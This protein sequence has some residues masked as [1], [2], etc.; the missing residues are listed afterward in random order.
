MVPPSSERID[1]FQVIRRLGRGGM[2]SVYLARDPDTDRLVA[3]KLLREGFDEE[4]L[5]VRFAAEARSASALRHINIVT[6]FQTGTFLDRPFIVMEYI[7]GE[8]FADL[9]ARAPSVPVSRKLQLMDELCTGLQYAHAK[10]VVHRDIKPA[11]VMIDQDG[12]VRILD[13]GI[14]RLGAGGL[15][16][17][18]AVIGTLNYM[19]PEQL[20]GQS[21][22]ARVDIFAAGLVLYEL[23]S[24][25]RAFPQSFPEVLRHIAVEEPQ[26]LAA[27][28]P[29]IHP[30]LVALVDRCLRK[31]PGDRY[32]DFGTL[33]RD[34]SAVRQA[35]DTQPVVLPETI[36]RT[37]PDAVS[38]DAGS[39]AADSPPSDTLRPPSASIVQDTIRSDSGRLQSDRWKT[40]DQITNAIAPPAIDETI[41][42]PPTGSTPVSPVPPA[43]TPAPSSES[44]SGASAAS[45]PAPSPARTPSRAPAPAAIVVPA[46][47]RAPAPR[48]ARAFVSAVVPIL[49]PVLVAAAIGGGVAIWRATISQPSSSAATPAPAVS[50][51]PSSAQA[52]AGGAAAV[53]S[54]QDREG[55]RLRTL[56]RAEWS[57]GESSS[58]L[59][60]MTEAQRLDPGSAE[61][62]LLKELVGDA[63]SRA[64]A[65]ERDAEAKK[66]VNTSAYRSGSEKLH[67]ADQLVRSG[68]MLQALKGY[69]EAA[70]QFGRAGRTAPVEPV[71]VGG[72]IKPPRQT[73]TVNPDYPAMARSARLEGVVILEATIG[74]TGK[75]TDVRVLRSIPLLDIAAMDAV[76]QWE[77]EPTILNGKAVPVI[78]TVTARFTLTPPQ[79]AVEPVRVGGAIKPPT[80]VKRVNP[81]YPADAQAAG[82]SGTV[83][84]DVTIGVDGTVTDVRVLRSIPKLDQ[85]AVDAVRQW[86]YAPTLRD[87]VAIPVITTVAVQFTLQPAAAPAPPPAAPARG[88]PIP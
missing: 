84:L 66:A 40:A 37:P 43:P 86:V 5:R 63:H 1:K 22:D 54:D 53:L 51:T 18:G 56:A 36:I 32:P 72:A 8:T 33:R 71:R 46:P 13:F 58:A 20:A 76:R 39:G 21:V 45:R 48:R 50:S 80:Q 2:G 31:Q 3:I 87:N 60:D 70:E 88:T 73:K 78:M 49:V 19:A 55:D 59:R 16:Q 35:L 14:A 65:A 17:T 25:R 7:E 30:G 81:V 10:G 4:E 62:A 38:T 85:A 41:V 69:L 64:S 42:R 6:I 11:N 79:P 61:D 47:K 34:L 27:L 26:S 83:I 9:I 74:V 44:G 77:Y 57:R 15:T 12:A 68:Q 24:S 67:A 23:L 29:G 52:R 82:I 28:C 75:V